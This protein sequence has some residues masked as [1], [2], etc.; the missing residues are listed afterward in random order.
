MP[1]VIAPLDTELTIVKINTDEKSKKHL[2]SLGININSIIKVISSNAGNLIV[3]IK[4]VRIAL[5]KDI[6][7]KIM[8]A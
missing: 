6:A 7:M 4:G 8:V 3:E 1:L 5:N 2:L